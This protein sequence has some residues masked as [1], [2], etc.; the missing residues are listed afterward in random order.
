MTMTRGFKRL[1]CLKPLQPDPYSALRLSPANLWQSLLGSW[2]LKHHQVVG[3]IFLFSEIK[4]AH[5]HLRHFLPQT[6]LIFLCLSSSPEAGTVLSFCFTEMRLQS[7]CCE[8]KVFKIVRRLE[9]RG[10]HGLTPSQ[11]YS[12]CWSN[13]T[14][15]DNSGQ[16]RLSESHAGSTLVPL[17]T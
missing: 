7:L 12:S 8:N 2:V 6:S 1:K 10:A 11:P 16:H 4:L 14:L 5:T 15:L 17:G 3:V 9:Q 13:P